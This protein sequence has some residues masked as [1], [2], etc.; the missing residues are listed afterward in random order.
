MYW[1][2]YVI[3]IRNNLFIPFNHLYSTNS[4]YF[5]SLIRWRDGNHL[6]ELYRITFYKKSVDAEHLRAL[7][8]F[9]ISYYVRFK[10]FESILNHFTYSTI[11]LRDCLSTAFI[12]FGD[13]PR[14]CIGKCRKYLRLRYQTNPIY[15]KW[16][17][18]HAYGK[19]GYKNRYHNAFAKI[20]F[21]MFGQRWTGIW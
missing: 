12:P 15:L 5:I 17:F 19:N 1:I 16:F 14:T 6:L 2:Q 3:K 18:R 11:N 4:S 8:A 13:G 9:K 21:W 10:D 20:S 7:V